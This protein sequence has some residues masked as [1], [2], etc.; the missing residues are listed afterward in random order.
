MTIPKIN[1]SDPKEH[2]QN[3]EKYI[4]EL[5]QHCLDDIN[6]VNEPKAKALF[7]TAADVLDGLEKAFSDYQSENAGAWINDPDRP[8]LQ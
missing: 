3:I 8:T 6:L 4:S 5:K 2:A 7:E 1:S